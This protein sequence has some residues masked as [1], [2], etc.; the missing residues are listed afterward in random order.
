LDHLK[1]GWSEA[2]GFL[3]HHCRKVGGA[4]M[5]PDDRRK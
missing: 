4:H 2:I 3:T 5:R 1:E